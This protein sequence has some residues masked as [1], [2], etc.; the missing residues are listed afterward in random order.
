MPSNHPL[1][2]AGIVDFC[3]PTLVLA[4]DA[5]GFLWLAALI[6]SGW[7]GDLSTFGDKLQLV[8]VQLGLM[9]SDPHGG[10]EGCGT[11]LCWRLSS[12][13]LQLFP[14]LLRALAQSGRDGHAYMDDPPGEDTSTQVIA[15]KGEYDPAFLFSDG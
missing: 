7:T 11:Q 15:S 14:E 9:H 6:E 10:L 13:A 1:L 3:E 2:S 12:A 8:G 5:E 4:G